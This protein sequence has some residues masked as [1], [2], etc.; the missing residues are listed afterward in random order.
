VHCKAGLGRTGTLIGCYMIY[1]YNFTGEEA[2]AWLRLARS[3]SVIGPQQLFLT[4][5]GEVLHKWKYDRTFSRRLTEFGLEGREK[6][7]ARFG[8]KGQAE[9]LIDT[10]GEGLSGVSEDE[11]DKTASPI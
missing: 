10:R 11:E 5:I 3:G 8:D 2:I 7:L 9:F 4:K 6:M 1:K